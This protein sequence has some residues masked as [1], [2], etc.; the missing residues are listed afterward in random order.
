MAQRAAYDVADNGC[1][2]RSGTDLLQDLLDLGVFRQRPPI[3]GN[4]FGRGLMKKNQGIADVI[5][6]INSNGDLSTIFFLAVMPIPG[7]ASIRQ[8]GTTPSLYVQKPHFLQ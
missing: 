8:I 1:E 7:R 5:G 4:V 2:P 3:Q 6:L